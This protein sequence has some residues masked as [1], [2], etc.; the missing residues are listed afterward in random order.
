MPSLCACFKPQED[1]VTSLDYRHCSLDFLPS[2]VF[3][4]ERTLEELFLDANQIRDLPRVNLP[5][6][7][8]LKVRSL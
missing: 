5:V 2:D 8:Y 6:K 3:T 1:D 7:F 4:A